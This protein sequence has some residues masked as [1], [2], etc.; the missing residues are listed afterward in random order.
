MCASMCLGK[1]N[2]E[3]PGVNFYR[4]SLKY[5][6][7]ILPLLDC[8]TVISKTDNKKRKKERKKLTQNFVLYFK[9]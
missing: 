4:L 3:L 5:L 6:P 1:S 8:Y 2:S 9:Y 7:R